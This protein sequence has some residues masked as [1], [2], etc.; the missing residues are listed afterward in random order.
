MCFYRMSGYI[1][2]QANMFVDVSGMKLSAGVF[3]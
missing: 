2:S 3:F 1:P